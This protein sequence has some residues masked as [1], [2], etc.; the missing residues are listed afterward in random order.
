MALVSLPLLFRYEL[1][2]T[3]NDGF[4]LFEINLRPN[5]EEF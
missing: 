1:G 5:E 4:A 2:S 3:N